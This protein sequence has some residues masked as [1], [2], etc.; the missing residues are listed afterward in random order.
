MKKVLLATTAL[1]LSAGVASAEVAV[2]GDARVGIQKIEGGD[3]TIERRARVKFSM[4]GETSNGIS[5]GASF[6]S[7]LNATDGN[8]DNV[9]NVYVSGAF[10][11]LSVG[12][13][14][15]AAEYAV[16]DLAGVGFTGAGSMNETAFA[17]GASVVYTYSANNLTAMASI[18]ETATVNPE[19]TDSDTASLGVKYVAG[20]L[21]IGAGYEAD[22][23]D[24][25]TTVSAAYA[26]GDTTVKGVFGQ[27]GDANQSG[28]SVTHAM[29]AV[30]LAAF[31]R[32]IDGSAAATY[33]AA[34]DGNYYGLGVS[35]DLGGG[36]A[37]NAGFADN[38][39]T[40]TV[41]AGLNFEF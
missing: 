9:G 3:T 41:E 25:N 18:G 20:A 37:A 28:V 36:A 10:G 19:T 21:T 34:A 15:S 4:S 23:A 5:F 13:E 40:S 29:D 6:R 1:V 27:M 2:S 7:H 16:G 33:G 38:D 30:T 26:M 17:N 32:N 8:E 31:Y 35:Y 11:T 12:S 22:A 14:S 39:G 24:A